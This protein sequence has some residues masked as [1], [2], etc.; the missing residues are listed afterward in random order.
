MLNSAPSTP[1]G[2]E[3]GRFLTIALSVQGKE[4]PLKFI[5]AKDNGFAMEYTP[6]PLA[7]NLID[8]HIKPFI[9]DGV[10]VRFHCR[11]G[12]HE[13]GNTDNEAS[14]KAVLVHLQTIDAVAGLG[15]PVITVHLNLNPSI[16]FDLQKAVENLTRLV[17]HGKLMGITVC[18]ENLRRGPASNPN[19]ILAWA[20]ASGAMITMDIGH[21][22]S[23][24]FVK[25]GNATVPDI[26]EMFSE[27]LYEVHMYAREEERHYP[28]EDITP[29]I[30]SLDCLLNTDCVWW[31]IELDSFEE[32]LNTRHRLLEYL[33]TK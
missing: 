4:Y 30:P 7:L 25:N 27:R 19:N 18:I 20:K 10:P 12:E 8:S 31:T 32:A 24:E 1:H 9:R 6:D 11:Y 3:P 29:L 21:A 2:G 15:E 13:I 23:S 28:I 26:V 17:N 33:S 22:V 14:E 16:P 5:Q